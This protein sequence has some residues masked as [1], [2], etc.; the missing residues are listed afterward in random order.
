MNSEEFEK[1]Y[2]NI[3]I[4]SDWV[5]RWINIKDK[6][7]EHHAIILVCSPKGM[8]CATFIDSKKMNIDLINKG[9]KGEVGDVNEHPY[10]FAS[11]EMKGH[12]CN[13]VTHWMPL[14]ELPYQVN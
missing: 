14:P 3:N 5:I 9:Y 12:T 6:L 1:H 10:Y 7:P 4:T 11:N 2:P 13:N 8:A